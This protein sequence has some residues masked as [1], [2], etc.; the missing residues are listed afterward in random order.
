MYDIKLAHDGSTFAPRSRSSAEQITWKRTRPGLLGKCALASESLNNASGVNRGP[1]LSS[2]HR[3]C[4]WY[5]CPVVPVPH[6]KV[7]WK[8]LF[9]IAKSLASS[10]TILKPLRALNQMTLWQKH[11]RS[12]EAFISRKLR[13]RARAQL[14]P[15]RR[16]TASRLSIARQHDALLGIT[17]TSH[18]TVD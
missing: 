11:C 12:F 5:V 16:T 10:S 14:P 17:V 7:Y 2:V 3:E 8:S 1:T 9:T 6:G 13:T 15:G 18:T 4:C